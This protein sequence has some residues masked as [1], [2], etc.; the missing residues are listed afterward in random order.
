MEIILSGDG[1]LTARHPEHG[2]SFHSTFGAEFE[3]QSLFIE[4]SG[5]L[6]SLQNQKKKVIV[7][8]LG[9]GLGLNALRGI[10][11]WLAEREPP[12]IEIVS[13]EID[14]GLIQQLFDLNND[15]W[16]K[17]WSKDRQLIC[18]KVSITEP[19]SDGQVGFADLRHPLA[20]STLSWRIFHG[21]ME[22]ILKSTTFAPIDFIWNDA[23]S[24]KNSPIC[25]TESFFRILRGQVSLDGNL[26]TYSVAGHV[27]KSLGA[28]GWKCF[29]IP[30]TTNK[31]HWLKAFP[32]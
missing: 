19:D 11:A 4:A 7:L 20:S 32:L 23:F 8:D 31:R 10:E 21:A 6:K 30:T 13:I 24:P 17:N 5:F 1:S 15:S 3:S 18:E 25:W 9:L 14:L 12:S 27:R 26:V 28:A 16:K 2:E 29:K 22:E